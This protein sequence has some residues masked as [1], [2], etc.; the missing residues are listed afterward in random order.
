M[1]LALQMVLR[2]EFP[3]DW[4][5]F[6]PHTENHL[7]SLPT[8][9]FNDQIRDG[10]HELRQVRLNLGVFQEKLAINMVNGKEQ[11][12]LLFGKPDRPTMSGNRSTMWFYVPVQSVKEIGCFSAIKQEVTVSLLQPRQ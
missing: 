11:I 7:W 5:S 12:M 4:Q 3:Q 10:F 8:G 1:S 6:F 2:Q 9:R